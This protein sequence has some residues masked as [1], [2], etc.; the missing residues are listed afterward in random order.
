MKQLDETYWDNRY[1]TENIG[2]D[3]GI[4][5]PPLKAYIDQLSD[6][7]MRILIPG[8]GHS[9]EAEYLFKNGFQN[10]YVVDVSKTALDNFSSRI[11]EFPKHQLLHYNFFDLDKT[12]DLIFE[13][14]FF[15]ALL[16]RLRPNYV[17]K[18]NDLLSQNGKLVGLLFNVPLYEDHPPFGG[19]KQEYIKHFKSLFHI[20]IMEP[21]HNSISERKGKELFIKLIKK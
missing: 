4:V 17:S 20:D 10:V 14:T 6:K 1:K 12:F 3:L 2:W 18:M 9:Y 19:H 13:Q 21:C 15:C 8:G 7:S 16:P 11:P 5:S